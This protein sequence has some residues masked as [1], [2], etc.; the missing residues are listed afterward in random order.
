MIPNNQKTSLLI[1][2][3]L[4][5]FIRDD[6]SYSTF[7]SFLEAYYEWMEQTN[8][9][10]DRSKNILNYTD[11]DNTTAEFIN[12][13]TQEYLSYFPQEILANKVEVIKIAKQLYESKGTTASYKFLFRILFNSDVSFFFTKEAVLKSSSGI[14]YVAKNLNVNTTDQNWLLINNL[15]LG[16]L[17]VFGETT[18][19]FATIENVIFTG[20][21]MQVYISNPVRQFISGEYV[22]VVDS[23]NQDYIVDDGT[24]KYTLR[25][26]IVGQVN[27]V[28]I[29]LNNPG[30]LYLPGDPVVFYGGLNPGANTTAAAQVAT[31]TKGSLPAISLINGGYGYR[32]NPNTIITIDSDADV[33]PNA[34]VGTVDIDPTKTANVYYVPTDIIATVA[35]SYIGNTAAGFGP[36]PIGNSVY[37]FSNNTSANANTSLA[38]AFN[39]IEFTT[40]PISSVLLKS[41]GTGISVVRNIYATS[42]YPVQSGSQGNLANLGIL[43]P[44]QIQSG[45]KGY[46]VNDTIVFNGG[47]GYGAY[48][49]VTS[50]NVSNGNTI[51]S[52]AYVKTNPQNFALGGMGYQYSLPSLTVNS[53]NG[54]A[55]GAVLYVPSILGVG[56]TFGAQG[57]R[58]GGITTIAVTDPGQ[59]YQSTPSVSLAVQDLSI[60]TPATFY[61]PQKGDILFQGSSY[62]TSTY[63]AIVDSYSI[64]SYSRV[65]SQIIYNVRVYNY[66]SAPVYNLPL[67]LKSNNQQYITLTNSYNLINAA[68]RY[69]SSGVLTYGDGSALAYANFINGLNVSSGQYLNSRGQ[70]SGFSVLQNQEYNNFTYE[71][72]AGAEIAKYRKVLLDL[73]HPTGLKVLGR[74]TI[75]SFAQNNFG[76]SSGYHQGYPLSYYTGGQSFATMVAN[77]SYPSTNTVSFT[78]LYG[79][80]LEQ[81]LVVG[82][83][84]LMTTANGFAVQ[85]EIA[86]VI[87]ASSNTVTL[88][89]SPWLS[90]ANVAYVT[91]NAGSN[92]INI[93]SLTNSYNV[94]NNGNYSNPNQPLRDIVF[95]GD[96]VVIS[97]NTVKTV[98]NVDY[99]NSVVYLTSNLTAYANSGS[100][101]TVNRTFVTSNVYIYGTVGVQYFPVITTEDGNIIITENGLQILLG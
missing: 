78:Y 95:T 49:N 14:W 48:A 5:A 76:A 45:G 90:F 34:V 71:L 62:D 7:T 74:Y 75:E 96:T 57:D 29:D 25:S 88:V 93:T 72:T 54:S 51:T 37:S 20:T 99:Q 98:S 2:Q 24:K 31:T 26:E 6:P 33:S 38:H 43:A 47:S 94:V 10:I 42:Y 68:S 32:F 85:S 1:P 22:R 101:M 70:P 23:N 35:N 36:P 86:S 60:I 58:L 52:V 63:S 97:N 12:Y 82:N 79:A 56:A 13:F 44:I 4:P 30:L 18:K 89:D 87:D 40:Y 3:Q 80:N 15:P 66:N 81:V 61:L 50:V 83:E 64:L 9:V 41:S 92:R 91:A 46:R 84:L 19:S 39:Y 100:L 55:S 53:A 27:Q 59:D 11:I 21:K 69:N 67:K 73:L 77:T 17:R 16:S 8:N 28:K 65:A